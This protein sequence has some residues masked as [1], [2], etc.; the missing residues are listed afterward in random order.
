MTILVVEDDDAVAGP[1]LEGL[2]RAGFDVAHAATGAAALTATDVDL[3]L[4][5]LGLPDL[6][7]MEVCRRLRERGSTPIIVISARGEEIDRVL[8]LELGADDYLVKPFG[9][10]EL[11][12]RV[13]AVMRRTE[14][15]SA[16]PEQIAATPRANAVY[17][18]GEVVCDVRSRRVTAKGEPVELT[19]KEFDLLAMLMAEPGRVFR[20]QEILETVWDPHWYGPSKT[21]D[22]HLAAVRRKLGDAITIATVRGV[23]FR[24]EP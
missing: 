10:R 2:R 23:G 3:V 4:L 8:L 9:M 7:G 18:V 20:R 1:L 6:D 16:S 17:E 24:I 19:P 12:A 11:V 14:A 15:A 22:V 13:R 21:I 5:D